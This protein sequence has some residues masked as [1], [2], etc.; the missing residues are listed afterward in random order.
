MKPPT[1]ENVE[2]LKKTAAAMRTA[3]AAVG[4]FVEGVYIASGKVPSELREVAQ[5]LEERRLRI[6]DI[7]EELTE[8]EEGIDE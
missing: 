1:Q 8:G 5:D 3:A 6:R 4:C 7:I 2:D